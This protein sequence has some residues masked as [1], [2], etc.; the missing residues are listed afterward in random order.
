M[1]KN[2]VLKRFVVFFGL[3]ISI[4]LVWYIIKKYDIQASWQLV[5]ETP[6]SFLIIMVLIYLSTFLFRALRWKLMLLNFPDLSYMLLLKSLI[7]GFAGNNIIPAKGGEFL[8]MEYFSTRTKISR[9]TSLSSIVLEKILDVFVLLLFLL[10]ASMFLTKTNEYFIYIIRIVSFFFLPIILFL[11]FFK[12]KGKQIIKWLA[13][14]DG[15]VNQFLLKFF[16][17][18]YASLSFLRADVNTI[19]IFGISVLI[20]FLEGLVFILGM[21]SVGFNDSLFL[22]GIIALVIVNFGILIPSSPGYI[23]VFQAATIIVLTSFGIPQSDGLAVGIII[24]SCQFFPVTI[25]G[26][27]ILLFESSKAPNIKFL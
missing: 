8:R 19:K 16:L 10:S 20:W 21:K 15:N 26:M 9:T 6:I 22:I 23:G 18:F 25:L 5:K 13:S 17:N 1:M 3:L 27:I 24:H 14:K 7:L 11:F 12:I 4:V 2:K